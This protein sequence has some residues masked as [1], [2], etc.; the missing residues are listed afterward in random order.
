MIETFVRNRQENYINKI[1]EQ[2]KNTKTTKYKIL[3]EIF[4]GKNHIKQEN[5][6]NKIKGREEG[7]WFRIIIG[8]GIRENGIARMNQFR[9]KMTSNIAL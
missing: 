3:V 5:C 2:T 8:W 1:K 6:I 7:K 4:A 9:R